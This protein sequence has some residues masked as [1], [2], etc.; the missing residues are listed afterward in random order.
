MQYTASETAYTIHPVTFSDWAGIRLMDQ[1]GV[2]SFFAITCPCGVE[3]KFP[4]NGL[5]S[6]STKHPCGNPDHWTIQYPEE[7]KATPDEAMQ[8]IR[9]M[10]KGMG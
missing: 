1:R 9:S 3:T 8:A 2:D 10:C 6:V 4:I 5:P 7:Q